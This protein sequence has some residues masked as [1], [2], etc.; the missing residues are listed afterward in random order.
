[1]APH[2][3]PLAVTVQVAEAEASQCWVPR[4]M[5]G[6]GICIICAV[7][8]PSPCPFQHSPH[9]EGLESMPLGSTSSRHRKAASRSKDTRAW[10]YKSG[11]VTRPEGL[12]V[13][14]WKCQGEASWGPSPTLCICWMLG[15][16]FLGHRKAMTL[17][18]VGTSLCPSIQKRET[19]Q[20]SCL[21]LRPGKRATPFQQRPAAMW[22]NF[23]LCPLGAPS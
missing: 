9:L 12:W 11:L 19:E 3:A 21:Q 2:G 23:Q 6:G 13:G 5:A 7:F 15:Q 18:G 10:R 20:T 8:G 16:S 17:T 1:M 22:S 14:P 4:A